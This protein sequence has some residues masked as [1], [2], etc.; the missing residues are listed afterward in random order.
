MIGIYCRISSVKEAGTDRSIKEQKLRGIEIAKDLKLPYRVY[1]DEG[2]SGTLPIDKRPGLSLLIDDVLSG[3]LN[4]IFAYDQS[5]LE[6]SP[7]TRM[8]LSQLF[9]SNNIDIYTTDGIVGKEIEDEFLGD[10]LSV[11]NNFYT[12][13]T[14]KK[15]KAVIRRNQL[16]G[17]IHG[18]PNYGYRKTKDRL[19][20]IDDAEKEIVLRI[21]CESLSNIGIT[22]IANGLNADGI[23]TKQGQTQWSSTVVRNIIVNSVYYGKRK[24]TVGMVDAP[25]IMTKEYWDKVQKNFKS[26][27]HHSGPTSTK[28]RLLR[29]VLKC[30]KDNKNLY[31]HTISNTVK[32]IKYNKDYYRCAGHRQKLCKEK[33][34]RVDV[35]DKFVWE[36]FFKEKLL[37][38]ITKEH[39]KE[40]NYSSKIKSISKEIDL[41]NNRIVKNESAKKRVIQ[42]VIDNLIEDKDVKQ[43]IED[44]NDIIRAAQETSKELLIEREALVSMQGNSQS[45]AAEI[46]RIKT[47]I[48]FKQRVELVLKYIDKIVVTREK[49]FIRLKFYYT[50]MQYP[51]SFYIDKDYNAAYSQRYKNSYYYDLRD[52][53]KNPPLDYQSVFKPVMTEITTL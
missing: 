10:M 28:D 12:K 45:E 17:K 6:R 47:E 24:T 26:N 33:G 43:K 21:Y 50:F 3:E 18:K 8:I 46:R 42:M 5:R 44:I 20:E 52:G 39:F 16:E 19:L 4:S 1:I 13:I 30:G 53:S 38:D 25:A 37:L 2:I 32:G 29:T 9:T 36:R 11:I 23:K 48:S 41:L 34:I 7:Q 35:I 27:S 49:G 31:G 22:R 15:I 14:S 40:T 51:N